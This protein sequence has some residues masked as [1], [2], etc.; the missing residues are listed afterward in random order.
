MFPANSPPAA[1]S[2]VMLPPGRARLATSSVPTGS[3]LSAITMGIV[4]VAFFAAEV[5]LSP[6]QQ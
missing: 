2:P 3:V 5:C 1:V 4:V 6:P